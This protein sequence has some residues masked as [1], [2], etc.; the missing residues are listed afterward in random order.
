MEGRALPVSLCLAFIL[1]LQVSTA[2]VA[3]TPSL[4]AGT[5]HSLGAVAPPSPSAFDNKTLFLRQGLVVPMGTPLAWDGYQVGKP[6]VILDGGVYKMWYFGSSQGG[7]SR[8]GYA[9]SPDGRN[10]T[11]LGPVLSPTLPAEGS[12]V[13]YPTVVKVGS[14]FRMWYNGWDGANW[15][16]LEARSADG[17]NWTKDGVVL[18]S[19]PVGSYDGYASL[20]P[21]VLYDAGAFRMYYTGRSNGGDVS[22]L[23]ALATS[24]DGL[25]WTRVGVVLSQG[26]AG[27]Y[28]STQAA[29]PSVFKDGATYA[30]VYTGRSSDLTTWLLTATSPD[31][32]S[33]TKLAVALGT[34]PPSE[35]LVAMP[36]LLVLANGTSYL[37]YAGRAGAMDL[38]VYLAWQVEDTQPPQCSASVQG[39][40]G[41]NGWYVSAA[42]V[43]LSAHDN[44]SGVA[45]ISYR[46]NGGTWRTYTLPFPVGGGRNVIGYRATDGLGNVGS[47]QTLVVSVDTDAPSLTLTQPSAHARQSDVT[48]T[49]IAVDLTSG[50]DHVEI[51][52][53]GGAFVDVGTGNG[54]VIRLSDGSHD[55]VVRALDRAGNGATAVAHVTVDTNPFSVSG[56]YYGIPVWV[57]LGAG[58]VL[59]ALAVNRYARSRPPSSRP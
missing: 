47:A 1:T 50:I 18:R 54:T 9:S 53:D 39:T 33:W 14:E 16:V 11:K 40:S 44:L 2:T 13:M 6:S 17:T 24:P 30:M 35:N 52:V 5:A 59:G 21:D 38:Q 25:N 20:F 36:S 4:G 28:D 15:T 51:G 58:V 27:S 42:T 3:V 57:L 49:W 10:W 8:I 56:P 31:G 45:S 37:Y 19:G 12:Q 22:D 34:L 29:F 46:L 32:L 55:I 43:T 48:I 41:Q 7:G 23:I 26:P